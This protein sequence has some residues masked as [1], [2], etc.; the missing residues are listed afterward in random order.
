MAAIFRIGKCSVYGKQLFSFFVA[1]F[2]PSTHYQYLELFSWR[3]MKPQIALFLKTQ[4][5]KALHFP[6]TNVVMLLLGIRFSRRI[7]LPVHFNEKC[8]VSYV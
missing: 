7:R 1:S 3:L 4:L 2:P 5:R 6:S 8:L